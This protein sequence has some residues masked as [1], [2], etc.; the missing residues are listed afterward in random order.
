MAAAPS[1]SSSPPQR[2][3]AGLN[4]WIITV[5]VKLATIMEVL[6]TTIAKGN[7][8][9]GYAIYGMAIMRAACSLRHVSFGWVSW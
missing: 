7:Y 1:H 3:A 2:S 8:A 5:A 6:D 4:K 9:E